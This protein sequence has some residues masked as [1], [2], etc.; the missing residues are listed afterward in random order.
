METGN[1]WQ[2]G[3]TG[4]AMNIADLEGM[5][6]ALVNNGVSRAGIY[7]TSY[8][9]GVITGGDTADFAGVANWV[10]GARTQSGAKSNCGL[11]PFTGAGS[12]I[13]LTQWTGSVDYDYPCP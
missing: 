7:S 4:L 8:Q 1:S 13:T 9:W 6:Q 11:A 12:K 3:S 10:P 5:E 2:S